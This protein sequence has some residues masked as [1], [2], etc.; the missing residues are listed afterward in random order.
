M[1]FEYRT[2]KSDRWTVAI[3]QPEVPSGKDWRLI[4]AVPVPVD[5]AGG[6]VMYWTWGREKKSRFVECP[7]D[8]CTS[9]ARKDGK[10]IACGAVIPKEA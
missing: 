5:D 10:C 2:N 4:S 1:K 8:S 7:T 3:P 6:K 9:V